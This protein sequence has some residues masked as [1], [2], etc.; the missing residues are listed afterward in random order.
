MRTKNRRRVLCGV[1]VAALCLTVCGCARA[2][3]PASAG[4][5]LG[6][7]LTALEEAGATVPEG[8]VLSTSADPAAGGHLSDTLAAA[9][10][11]AAIRE[12]LAAVDG[13]APVNDMA[14]FLSASPHPCELAILR[15]SDA[16]A[17]RSAAGV[18][19]TRLDLVRRAWAGSDY[20]AVTDR[21]AVAMEGSFVLLV[22]ADDPDAALDGARRAIRAGGA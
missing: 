18:C 12:L 19:H 1:L 10:F 13:V 7:M 14:V 20:A 16:G 6:G 3:V 21:A 17:A 22:I 9:L 11:G 8:M 15:C 2:R 4:E 5:V